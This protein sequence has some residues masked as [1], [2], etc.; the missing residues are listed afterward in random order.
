ML[1]LTSLPYYYTSYLGPKPLECCSKVEKLFPCCVG[2]W[3]RGCEGVFIG[4]EEEWR[5][6]NAPCQWSV[7]LLTTALGSN[8]HRMDGEDGVE[9]CFLACLPILSKLSSFVPSLLRSTCNRRLERR[10]ELADQSSGQTEPVRGRPTPNWGQIG[11]SSVGDLLRASRVSLCSA[12][13]KIRW[14]D[15]G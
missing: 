6:L 11:P 13:T 3:I 4:W 8:R 2:S 14:F 9:L 7:C 10:H 5:P 1:S 12:F 15:L